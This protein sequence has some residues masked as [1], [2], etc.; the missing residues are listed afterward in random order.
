MQGRHIT[1]PVNPYKHCGGN[2]QGVVSNPHTPYVHA[3]HEIDQ[4]HVSSL[5]AFDKI[6]SKV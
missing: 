5:K 4:S 1:I 3:K 2:L 6:L